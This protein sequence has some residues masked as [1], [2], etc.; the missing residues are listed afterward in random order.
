MNAESAVISILLL[1][2]ETAGRIVAEMEPE[3]F[4]SAQNRALFEAAARMT[5]QG[6]AIDAIALTNEAGKDYQRYAAEL[7]EMPTLVYALDQHMAQAKEDRK[8]QSFRRLLDEMCFYADTAPLDELQIKAGQLGQVLTASRGEDELSAQEAMGRF[9]AEQQQPKA[10]IKTGF[11]GLD[12]GVYLDKGDYVVIGGRPSAGKTAFAL[13]L[14]ANLARER[15]VV[16]FS[17]ETQNSKIMD[18]TFTGLFG[19]EFTRVKRHTLTDRDFQDIATQRDKALGLKFTVVNAAG[20]SVA[21]MRAKAAKLG[22]EVIIV[23]YLGLVKS[24]GQSRYEQVTQTSVDLH[25]L[26]QTSGMLVIALSQ[27]NRQGGD[28]PTMKD[29]RE[30]GQIEQ[31]ADVIL[32]LQNDQTMDYKVIVAKNKEGITG[33]IPFR[34][35]GNKQRFYSVEATR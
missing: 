18:R 22:A 7:I 9:L 28:V 21:W 13:S 20:R 8:R 29:L 16:F 32:L 33:V 17:L 6:K 2:P 4:T 10:Y 5:Q 26:A 14:A 24:K 11:A 15:Q 31:D 23:D 35:E 25:I 19:L 12:A 30:S 27:L 34:F 1:Y 3:D